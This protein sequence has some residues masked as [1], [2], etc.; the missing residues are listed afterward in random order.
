MGFLDKECGGLAFCSGGGLF[1]EFGV[2]NK[3]ASGGD[4]FRTASDEWS[5]AAVGDDED[6][7]SVV[8]NDVPFK[9]PLAIV[10]QIFQRTACKS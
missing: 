9:V 7:Y 2:G 1:E 8:C 10:L 6:G 3:L 5:C 4:I